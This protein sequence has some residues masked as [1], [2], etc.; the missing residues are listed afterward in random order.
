M[1][2][3]IHLQSPTSEFGDDSIATEDFNSKKLCVIRLVALESVIR[4]LGSLHEYKAV[5]LPTRL[6]VGGSKRSPFLVIVEFYYI[7]L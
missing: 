5:K 4:L 1:Y 7:A 3:L 6:A 2:V